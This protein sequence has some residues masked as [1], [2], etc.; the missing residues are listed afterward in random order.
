MQKA[1]VPPPRPFYPLADSERLERL[2]LFFRPKAGRRAISLQH[3]SQVSDIGKH[4][5]TAASTL[6]LIGPFGL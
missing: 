5:V 3:G 1:W 4:L 6:A 2:P